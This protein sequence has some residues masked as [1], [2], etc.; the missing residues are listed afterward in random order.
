VSNRKEMI[1]QT[2]VELFNN[3][4]C[5]NTS[6]RHIADTLGISVG[7]LYYYFKN[8]EDI[9]VAIY[10]EFMD[11]VSVHLASV[12]DG[13]DEVFDFY[14]FL[15]DQMEIEKKYRFMRLEMNA[16]YQ[17]YPKMKIALEEGTKKKSEEFKKLYKHQMKY[18]YLID[19]DESEMIFFRANTWIVG[20][21]WELYWL[22]LEHKDEKVRRLHGVLNLLYFIKPYVTKKGLEKSTLLKSIEHVKKEIE[23]A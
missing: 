20:S 22:L 11:R 1:L 6:T 10:E 9:I 7:N 21:Q 2:A 3:K 14:G 15:K 19:L 5:E 12:K 8:K 16:L 13:V 17:N 23:N 18:G 4:G